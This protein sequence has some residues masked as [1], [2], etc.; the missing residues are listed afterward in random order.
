MWL[1]WGFGVFGQGVWLSFAM[2]HL[3]SWVIRWGWVWSCKKLSCETEPCQGRKKNPLRK[4]RKV[5]KYMCE[6][7]WAQGPGSH[8]ASLEGR[9]V[10]RKCDETIL[11]AWLLGASKTFCEAEHVGGVWTI[12]TIVHCPSCGLMYGL[13][14]CSGRFTDCSSFFLDPPALYSIAYCNA[15]WVQIRLVQ[16]CTEVLHWTFFSQRLD[17]RAMLVT[18][19]GGARPPN[20]IVL[21]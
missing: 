17:P 13:K 16:N 12:V 2:S 11:C 9:G 5:Y 1:C 6:A 18:E 15:H 8:S 10:A 3:E 14:E 21:D 7:C 4:R 19:I 20:E